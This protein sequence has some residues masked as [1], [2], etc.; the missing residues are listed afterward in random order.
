MST[1]RK[2][3]VLFL[4]AALASAGV[5]Q[6][7]SP[8]DLTEAQKRMTEASNKYALDSATRVLEPGDALRMALIARQYAAGH[9]CE[10]I[11]VDAEKFRAVMQDIVAKLDGLVEEGQ[12]NAAVDAVMSAYSVSLG[13]YLA[14]A[15]YDNETFCAT[16]AAMRT[17]FSVEGGERVLV[18]K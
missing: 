18:L 13:G 17:T 15:A 7:V 5:A 14:A 3:P 1:T 8:D 12:N 6:A 2:L 9:S 4:A 11:E 10:G 16:A